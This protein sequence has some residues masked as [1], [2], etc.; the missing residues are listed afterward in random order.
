M[1]IYDMSD[2]GERD[3]LRVC[4]LFSILLFLFHNFR[5]W[6]KEHTTSQTD[7]ERGRVRERGGLDFQVFRNFL[8]ISKTC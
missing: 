5:L 7:S 2:S 4:S 8:T 3:L 6:G 1:Y